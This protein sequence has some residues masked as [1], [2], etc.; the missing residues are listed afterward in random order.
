M[1][2]N[3]DII[4]VYNLVNSNGTKLQLRLGRL[5]GY[6]DELLSYH[7]DQGFRWSFVGTKIPM[8]VRNGT[9]FNGFPENIMLDW[10][11]GNGWAP[12]SRV[13]M[14][15]GKATVYELPFHDEPSK[16]NENTTE[17]Y[18]LSDVAIRQGEAALTAAIRLLCNNGSVLSAVA[19]YRYV[20]PCTLVE[21]KHA[22]DAM[23]V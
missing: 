3:I 15:T 18:K 9:W 19:L 20:C 12:H 14:G 5:K 6:G 17:E 7:C 1:R 16:R 2:E 8:P 22:V 21:A 10:L 4:V 13:D 23:R 11:K